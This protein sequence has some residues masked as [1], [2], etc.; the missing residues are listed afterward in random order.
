M[1]SNQKYPRENFF[2]NLQALVEIEELTEVEASVVR[3]GF[4]VNVG[5]N[6]GTSG[7][8]V[9]IEYESDLRGVDG[10]LALKLPDIP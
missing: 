3:G 7:V 8:E 10:I 2:E 4:S 9:E 6:N 1:N 5:N